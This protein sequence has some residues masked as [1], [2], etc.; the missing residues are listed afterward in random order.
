MNARGGTLYIGV[1][2]SGYENGLEDDLAY[3][4]AHNHKATIDGMIVDLQN[5]L[6]RTMPSHA[7]DHWE[8]ESD[9]EAKKG[10]IIVKVLPVGTPVE[11]DGIIYVRSSSTTKPRLDEEREEFI[12]NRDS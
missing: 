12:K 9:P 7:K 5:Q 1:N 10:V 6:D 8:I 4:K 11:L 3:R 2:D